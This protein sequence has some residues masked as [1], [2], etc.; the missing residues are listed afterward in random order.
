M[1]SLEG[2]RNFPDIG[3]ECGA[4][5]T[6]QAKLEACDMPGENGTH[7]HVGRYWKRGEAQARDAFKFI[8]R[9]W[10][11]FLKQWD[12]PEKYELA[13]GRISSVDCRVDICTG[14]DWSPVK[15]RCNKAECVVSGPAQW[16]GLG[17]PKNLLRLWG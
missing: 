10:I 6:F 2:E 17:N 13:C 1:L 12:A 4:E 16:V 7:G 8:L 3:K 9:T 15:R 11:L 14:E 5:R